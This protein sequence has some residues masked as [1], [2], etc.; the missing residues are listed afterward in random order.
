MTMLR[1]TAPGK[2]VLWG[3]Y[4]V[5]A[6]APAVALAVD[7]LA[8]CSFR[9]NAATRT[10]T[11]TTPGLAAGSRQLSLDS[12]IISSQPPAS[13]P[14]ALLWHAVCN[15]KGAA[16]RLPSGGELE[17][18]ST[19]FE[20]QGTKLGLGS[21]AAVCTALVA[22]LRHLASEP[23]AEPS[24]FQTHRSAQNG[25][26]SGIDVAAA[27][28]GGMVLL[29]PN[30]EEPTAPGVRTYPWPEKLHW[31]ALWTG[32]PAATTT[33]IQRFDDWVGQDPA[34]RPAPLRYLMDCSETLATGFSLDRFRRYIAALHD[35]DRH[36][37]LGIYTD[38]HTELHN[39]ARTAGIHYKPCGAGGGDAGIAVSDDP[40]RLQAFCEAA[41]QLAPNVHP[42]DL[43]LANHGIRI[44]S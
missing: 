43:R 24:A 22:L 30:L 4:A 41:A 6:G 27:L 18:D 8:I 31:R 38:L 44:S 20:Y 10:W 26:G 21:S 36:G 7:R 14:E 42:L 11:L 13:A 28:H 9:P 39:L 15:L 29:Q 5:L 33:H 16:N 17:L 40:S 12:L 25:K 1:A 3:E 32:K 2:L 23:A 19:A 35:V 34:A 37:R